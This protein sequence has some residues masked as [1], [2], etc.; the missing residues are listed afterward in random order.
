MIFGAK[1]KKWNRKQTERNA[2]AHVVNGWLDRNSI[3]HTIYPHMD[4]NSFHLIVRRVYHKF[5]VQN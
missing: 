1:R 4:A 3:P 5:L 2:S